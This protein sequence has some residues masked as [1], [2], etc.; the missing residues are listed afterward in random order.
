MQLTLPPT[1]LLLLLVL[2]TYNKIKNKLSF[3]INDNY[4]HISLSWFSC[5]PIILIELEVGNVAG[6]FQEG[7]KPEL[8]QKNPLS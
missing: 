3:K 7:G 8:T 1:R 5:R 4:S 6:I 2:L